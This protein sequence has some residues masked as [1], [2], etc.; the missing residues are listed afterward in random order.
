M[1]SLKKKVKLIETVEKWLS[2]AEG[3]TRNR[4]RFVKEYRLSAIK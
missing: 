1:R 3:D 4:E 2:G